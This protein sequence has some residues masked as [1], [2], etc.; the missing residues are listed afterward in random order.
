[1]PAFCI[2][3][4]KRINNPSLMEQYRNSVTPIVTQFDGKYVAIG[5]PMVMVEGKP[6]VTFPVIIEFPNLARAREW[7]DS[8]EYRPVK[9]MREQAAE[10]QAYFVEGL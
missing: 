1:M 6:D 5:G 10:T 4:V 7:Y 3:D 9:E 2:F 8:S